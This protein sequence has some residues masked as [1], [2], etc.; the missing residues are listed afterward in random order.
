MASIK[1][2]Q[3]SQEFQDLLSQSGSKLVVVDFY[4]TWCG[5]CHM[6]APFFA[7]ISAK[8]PN[9]QF[10]KVDVDRLRDVAAACKVTAM[11]TFQ[12]FKSGQKV[13]ELKGASAGQIEQLVKKHQGETAS[14]ILPGQSLTNYILY[15]QSDITDYITPN[16]MDALNQQ[17]ENNVKN[18][19]KSDDSF[20]ESDVDEQ[21]IITVPFNQPVKIHSIKLKAKNIAQAPK[22]I[23]IYVNRQNL[24]FD[25]AD[26]VKE[27]Q[28][29][30][31][32]PK[33]FEED[34]VVNLRFV[35]FQNVNTLVIFVQDNQEDEETTQIQ[36]IVFIGSPIEA[37][38]MGNLKKGDEEE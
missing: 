6:I 19:F 33:D 27:T 37:T 13:A 35:K 17:D 5:P 28:T 11:P 31:L 14:V 18:V 16:Q 3:T 21:L 7:Q 8:Y 34:A 32:E 9:V 26:S 20:L 30:E 15:I 36:Q 10:A 24:G 22:T 4:A 38:N 12:Y 1:E 29:I 25:E 23:K 2:L